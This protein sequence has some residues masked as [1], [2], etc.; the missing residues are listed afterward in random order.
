MWSLLF[1]GVTCCSLKM[2]PFK[3][4]AVKGSNSKEKEPVIDVDDLSLKPKRTW[5][6]TRVYEPHKFRLYAAFRTYAKYFW[7]A[8]LLVERVVD[9]SS[10]L[11]TEIPIWFANKNWNFLL[12]NLDEVYENLVRE[13]YAN[14][15][16]EGKELKCWVK[17]KIFSVTPTYL[18]EIIHLNRSILPNPPVYDDLCPDKDLL[19]DALGRNLEFSQ[20]GNSFNVSSLPSELRVLT[21][22]VF[23]NLYPLSSTGYMNLGRAL[24]LQDLITDEEIDICAHIFHI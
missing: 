8:S 19:R 3:R 1:I 14:A 12:S 15:I 21:L 4:S 18:A 24:F 13:F 5:S 11:D 22:I 16:I 20:N 9:Q 2:S 6:P 10:L 23:N 17:G 7:D